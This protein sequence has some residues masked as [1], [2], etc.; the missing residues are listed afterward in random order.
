MANE[1]NLINL[2]D[3]PAEVAR[4][5]RSKGGKARAEQA[6]ER[7]TMRDIITNALDAPFTHRVDV[8]ERNF[9]T[10]D[11]ESDYYHELAYQIMSRALC[12]PKYTALLLQIVGDLPDKNAPRDDGLGEVVIVEGWIDD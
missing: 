1:N 5:I 11:K 8:N 12:D 9:H 10:E 6:R 4:A 3:R 2:N 7:A